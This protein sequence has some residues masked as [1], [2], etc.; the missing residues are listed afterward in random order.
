ML[1]LEAAWRCVNESRV[2][3]NAASCRLAVPCAL[4]GWSCPLAIPTAT[5]LGWRPFVCPQL[6]AGP[7][8]MR[9]SLALGCLK[10]GHLLRSH[11]SFLWTY[12]FQGHLP[13]DDTFSGTSP[14]WGCLFPGGD[15]FPGVSPSW[16]HLLPKDICFLGTSSW[17]HLPGDHV[18]LRTSS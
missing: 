4:P 7:G 18:F 2:M 14:F 13:A 11:V 3:A 1:L 8:E 17:K 12:S 10:G 16:G 6:Q 9:V 15:I 5:S